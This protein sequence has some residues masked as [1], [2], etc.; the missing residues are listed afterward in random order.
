[1]RPTQVLSLFGRKVSDDVAPL[2]LAVKELAQSEDEKLRAVGLNL[3]YDHRISSERARRFI[4]F[5]GPLLSLV[6]PQTLVQALADYRREWVAQ[7]PEETFD[8]DQENRENCVY[9]DGLTVRLPSDYE[10]AH[11]CNVTQSLLRIADP[12]VKRQVPRLGLPGGT[13]ASPRDVDVF[14]RQRV[15]DPLAANEFVENF[16][17]LLDI[18]RRRRPWHPIWVTNWDSFV[19]NIDNGRPES[20]PETVGLPI[21]SEPTWLLVLRY[22]VGE[23]K[24]RIYRPTQ[25]EAGAFAWHFPSPISGIPP[26]RGGHPMNLTS[27]T[28]S[29]SV[30]SEFVHAQIRFEPEY[31]IRA[32]PLF[33]RSGVETRGN[34]MAHRRLHHL[35]LCEEYGSTQVTNWMPD[36]VKLT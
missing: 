9:D 31:Y 19:R 36:A 15:S 16:L 21:Q 27:P 32:G 4:S 10:L 1:M 28:A 25:L 18:N 14:V 34:L 26:L 33:R 24:R 12:A 29:G 7:L 8:H 30:V 35:A 5:L 13:F 2:F 22:S 11:V 23:A 20:W 17:L 6:T 3:L